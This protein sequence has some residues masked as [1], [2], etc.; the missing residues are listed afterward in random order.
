VAPEVADVR[1]SLLLSDE[2]G[3]TTRRWRIIRSVD[4]AE[5][6]AGALFLLYPLHYR[7]QIGRIEDRIA[8][9]GGNAEHFANQMNHRA[10]RI[11]LVV[12]P[13]VGVALI[14]LGLTGN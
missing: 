3:S 12:A 14:V 8:T 1:R 7:W 13:V 10:I 9:R 2:S 6:I 11:S 4:V 5:L